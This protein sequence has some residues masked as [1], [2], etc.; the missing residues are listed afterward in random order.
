MHLIS[1]EMELEIRVQFYGKAGYGF[2]FVLMPLN[3]SF[4]S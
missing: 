4:S 3:E 2:H 1:F